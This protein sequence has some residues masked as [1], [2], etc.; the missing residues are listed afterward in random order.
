MDVPLTNHTLPIP[1]QKGIALLQF[2]SE[3]TW[4]QGKMSLALLSPLSR[5]NTVGFQGAQQPP[6]GSDEGQQCSCGWEC[7][8]GP[9][10][11]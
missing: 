6:L 3:D 5:E 4:V 1:R 9:G 7:S 8:G 10:F 2:T 11:L